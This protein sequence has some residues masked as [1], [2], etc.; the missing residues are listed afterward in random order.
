MSTSIPA[1]LASLVR[2]RAGGVCEYCRLPQASQEATFHVDHIRPLAVGGTTTPFNLALACVTCS[3]R[4]AAR[5]QARDPRTRKLVRLFNPRRDDWHN[6]FRWTSSW[7]LTGRSPF[8]RATIV[9]LGMNR[10]AVVAIRRVLA[11]MGSFPP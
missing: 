4:K 6:H 1:R 11:D 10:P 3:L 7:Q 9:A 5:T 2:L 8:G